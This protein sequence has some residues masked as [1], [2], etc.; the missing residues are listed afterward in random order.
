MQVNLISRQAFP[1][2]PNPVNFCMECY[3]R[4]YG[5]EATRAQQRMERL[6]HHKVHQPAVEARESISVDELH[7]HAD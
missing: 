3:E 6:P 1:L 7:A 5:A 4:V 2:G